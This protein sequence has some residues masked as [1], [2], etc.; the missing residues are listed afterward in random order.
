MQILSL[1]KW[2]FFDSPSLLRGACVCV[3]QPGVMLS[4]LS[5]KT[6]ILHNDCKARSSS[7]PRVTFSGLEGA[8]LAVIIH[9]AVRLGVA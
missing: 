2:V 1:R 3:L 5:I 7:A 8:L 6:P 9:G 4:F